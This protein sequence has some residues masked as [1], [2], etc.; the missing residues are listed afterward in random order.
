MRVNSL[1]EITFHLWVSLRA[2]E[3]TNDLRQPW[4]DILVD[5]SFAVPCKDI[6]PLYTFD[7]MRESFLLFA[8]DWFSHRHPIDT[9]ENLVFLFICAIVVNAVVIAGLSHAVWWLMYNIYIFVC[10]SCWLLSYQ[11]NPKEKH[12]VSV[13]SKLRFSIH[14][15]RCV[16]R[17]S[18]NFFFFPRTV[19]RITWL[20]VM[21]ESFTLYN[22]RDFSVY[23]VDIQNIIRR[24]LVDAASS[25]SFATVYRPQS[26]QWNANAVICTIL[27]YGTVS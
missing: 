3:F 16:M 15:L 11:L 7:I 12:F 9:R 24:L 6:P 10:S 21:W 8:N 25:S 26:Q 27:Y 22:R 17:E 14:F 18:R 23:L 2:Y 19:S 13:K 4:K 5:S 20:N 1:K